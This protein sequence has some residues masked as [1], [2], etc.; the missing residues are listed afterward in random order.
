MSLIL[1]ALRKS[2]AERQRGQAP[3]L[4]TPTAPLPARRRQVRYTPWLIAV[5]M[6]AIAG[7]MWWTRREPPP[8]VPP[9]AAPA[10][11]ATPVAP[12]PPPPP[13]EATGQPTA[14]APPGTEPASLAPALP[15]RTP[16]ATPPRA[17]RAPGPDPVPAP[18]NGSAAAVAGTP[19]G[20]LP[21]L[22]ELEAGRRNELPPLK[23][24]MHV[25]SEQPERRIAIIDGQRVGEGAS[26]GGV[27]VVEIRRDG[28]ALEFDGR[29]YLLPRP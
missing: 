1:D 2:E 14:A 25:W 12:R 5:A 21:R 20:Y 13:P 9:A 23:L 6:L 18:V 8:P 24:S 15:A 19:D 3:G 17:V 4:F 27:V 7:T 11:V 22:A 28:V 10:K 26:V 29:R 16:P